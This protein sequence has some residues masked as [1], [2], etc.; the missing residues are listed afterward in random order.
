MKKQ[1]LGAA[2]A[3]AALY[4]GMELLGVTCPIRFL[5]GISCAGCGMSRAWLSLLRL[6]MEAA[7]RYHPLFLLPI[8]GALLLLFRRRVS[9]GRFWLGIWVLCG[10]FLTV[11][12]VRLMDP[13]DSI[14]TFE[15]ARGLIG[16]MLSRE[17]ERPV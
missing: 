3:A 17:G 5:T 2:A 11:Y 6:D 10:L 9:R 1:D 4:I 8:P 15:P 14:V 7:F 13:A 16:R 12:V